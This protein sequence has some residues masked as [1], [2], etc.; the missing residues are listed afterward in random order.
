[1]RDLTNIQ[2]GCCPADGPVPQ[3]AYAD[4]TQCVLTK[5]SDFFKL[6]SDYY[7]S[8][9]VVIEQHLGGSRYMVRPLGTVDDLLVSHWDLVPDIAL[10]ESIFTVA[11]MLNPGT[12][13][14]TMRGARKILKHAN[15]VL[16]TING[17]E[18]DP[19][20]LVVILIPRG[21]E[22]LAES[23]I[24]KQLFEEPVGQVGGSGN[25]EVAYS[26]GGKKTNVKKLGRAAKEKEQQQ[27][28]A[29]Q[30]ELMQKIFP[31][32]DE[33]KQLAKK[34]QDDIKDAFTKASEELS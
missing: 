10:E 2:Y 32:K 24:I 33:F 19:E 16:E 1:M 29:K 5:Q 31:T 14:K 23:M 25:Y 20:E 34:T 17:S 4:G 26:H 13:F 9:R 12:I 18:V 7:P 11:S 30:L 28:M 22:L 8:N 15:P 3:Y 27:D 21:K 6:M